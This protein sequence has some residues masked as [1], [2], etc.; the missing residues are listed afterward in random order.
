MGG[1]GKQRVLGLPQKNKIHRQRKGT[2]GTTWPSGKNKNHQGELE[3]ETH[4]D[5]PDTLPKFNMEP[6]NGT[7]E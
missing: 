4:L 2:S 6:E 5:L 1:L 3:E 7:L